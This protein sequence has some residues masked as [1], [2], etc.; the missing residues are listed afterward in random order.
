MRRKYEVKSV[1]KVAEVF[2]AILKGETLFNGASVQNTRIRNFLINGVQCA[3]SECGRQGTQFRVE[4][5]LSSIGKHWAGSWHL[6]LYAIKADGELVMM[7]RDHIIPRSK[8]GKTTLENSQTLCIKCNVLKSDKDI[9]ASDIFKC[10]GVKAK[11]NKRKKYIKILD[12]KKIMKLKW[13]LRAVRNA[14]NTGH[15]IQL[16]RKRIRANKAA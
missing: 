8:G 10:R 11:K 5:D 9:N 12:W 2:D 7:T 4:R 6:N 3:N 13:W 16:P 1:H 15:S 14:M